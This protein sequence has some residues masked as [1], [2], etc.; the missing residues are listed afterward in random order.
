MTEYTVSQAAKTSGVSV[1]T[2]HHYDAI[3]LLNPSQRSAS[4][5]RL[6]S[7]SDLNRLADI[8]FYRALGFSLKQ[9]DRVLAEQPHNR[10]ALLSEQ[11]QL[12]EAH[13]DR[14]QSIRQHLITS[15]E[16]EENIMANDTKFVAFDGFDPD[17]YEA[18]AAQQWGETDAYKE[19][20]RRTKN[21]T[22]DDWARYKREADALNREMVE[23]MQAGHAADSA[24][25]IAVV[26]Q[27]RQ[28]IDTWFYPCSRQMH[29]QLGEMYVID[30]RFKATYEAIQDGMAE[31]MKQATAAN[32]A[33]HAVA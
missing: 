31:F 33:K 9:I 29:A 32:L 24:E 5:Y 11:K 6:Y 27:M 22:K 8:L 15:L 10:A 20:T 3:G 19:S 16:H 26:E 28:Q 17:Q 2:L 1:R 25:A 23:V 13:I 7:E 21:Y 14:L 30:E 12:I 18:E 4:G